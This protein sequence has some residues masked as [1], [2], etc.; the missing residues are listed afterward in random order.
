M[1]K[2][3]NRQMIRNYLKPWL[4][5]LIRADCKPGLMIPFDTIELSGFVFNNVTY[6]CAQVLLDL[7]PGA[8]H[9]L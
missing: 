6:G 2:L 9:N 3:Q 1:P 4:L 5:R 7:G 8:R